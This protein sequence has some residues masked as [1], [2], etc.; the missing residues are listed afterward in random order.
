VTSAEGASDE[1]GAAY[2]W[3]LHR[4]ADPAGLQAFTADLENGVPMEAIL[5]AIVGSNEYLSDR[6]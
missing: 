2:G 1:V 4:A 3:L 6:V 5:A